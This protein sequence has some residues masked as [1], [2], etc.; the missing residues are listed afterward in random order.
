VYTANPSDKITDDFIASTNRIYAD[1]FYP[2][3]GYWFV[4]V[5]LLENDYY[6]VGMTLYPY[7]RITSHIEGNGANFTKKHKPI[8]ICELYCLNISNRKVCYK[9]ETEKTKQYRLLYG[10]HKVVGGRYLGLGR[11]V[12]PKVI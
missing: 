4:Y 10:A 12:V 7:L 5:L 11:E 8:K 6:Y 1:V 9:L 3:K 2:N